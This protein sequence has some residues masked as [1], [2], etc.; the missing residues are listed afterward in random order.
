MTGGGVAANRFQMQIVDGVQTLIDT[1]NGSL[2]GTTEDFLFGGRN[3]DFFFANL[4]ALDF[5]DGDTLDIDGGET[6]DDSVAGLTDSKQDSDWLLIEASDDDEPVVIR[7]ANSG[8]EGSVRTQFMQDDG[9]NID[10]GDAN[11]G[12]DI[13]NLENVDASGN[14][15]GFLDDMNVDMGENGTKVGGENVGIGS[16]AQFDIEGN[17]ARNILIA[18]FDNDY[19]KGED[20]DDLLFGGRLDYN[21]NPNVADIV[22]DGMDALYGGSGNDDIAFETD[23]GIYEGDNILN[24]DGYASDTLWLT[25]LSFGTQ[26]AGEVATDGAVRMDLGVGMVGGLDNFSGYG[27]ADQNASGGYTADQTNYAGMSRTTVQDMENVIATGLGAVDYVAAGTNDPELNFN[28]QQN[29]GGIDANLDL[30]GTWYENTLYA[31]TGTDWIEGRGGDDKLSGGAGDDHFVF[32]TGEDGSEGVDVIHRQTDANGDNL[33]DG[34]DHATRTGGDFERDFGNTSAPIT[35]NSKLTLTLVDLTNPTDLTGFP[36]DGV[37]FGLDGVSYTVTLSSGVQ[38]TYAAFTAGLNAALDADAALAHLDAVLNADNTITITDP[39]G[40]TFTEGGYTFINDIVPPAGT[41]QWDQAVGGPSV[42]QTQDMLHYRAYEDRAD[43]ELV[44]DDSVNG[45]AISLGVDGYAEDRVIDFAADGTRIAED[46]YYELYFTNLTTQDVVTIN[47]NGVTYELKVGVDLDGNIIAGEDTTQ[48]SLDDIQ[49]NFLS[50]MSNFINTFMDDDTAAGQIE[51]WSNSNTIGLWQTAYSDGEETVFMRTPV[52]TLGNASGGEPATVAVSNYSDHEVLLYE[53]DGRNNELNSDNVVFEG[54]T[55]TNRAVLETAATAGG[56][57]AGS[58]AIVVDDG[59]NDLKDTVMTDGAVIADNTATNT[60]FNN[61]NFAAHGDDLLL[62]GTGSDTI[63][64]GTGDDRVLGSLGADVADGGK[65]FY[66]VKVLGEAQ[67]RVYILNQWEAQNPTKVT[68]LSGLTISS[69]TR[70]DDNESGGGFASGGNTG[71]AEVFQDTLQFQQNDFVSGSS[72]FTVTL[73]N[74]ATTAQGV[75]ELR[76]GGAGTVGVD[77]DGNGSIDSTTT[78]TN[79]E[80]IRTVSGIGNA[81]A[82][83]GQ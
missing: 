28:N 6:A 2:A 68:E 56:V 19:V 31:N 81:V 1:T 43:G 18:G 13:K 44:N 12:I 48:T 49:T 54:D 29:I 21:N 57:L 83:D 41:L 71:T 60:A 82:G 42:T 50:R 27:G 5:A 46:Q 63:T 32:A 70:I 59:P 4:S 37:Q 78:F 75:V 53:F 30:R 17:D 15:Y 69:I 47:V 23:G 80:N 14:L 8:I 33:W 35:A 10:S 16:T 52:V 45:S 9:G 66:A 20:G 24:A 79:F 73:N 25:E 22:N 55:L 58:N 36:V 38:D 76:N 72:R 51:T 62:G 26:S 34:F 3:A 64:G 39:A 11:D 77:N 61:A 40:K 65:S 67:S 74:F 7:L